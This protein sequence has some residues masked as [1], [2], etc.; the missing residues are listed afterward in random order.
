MIFLQPGQKSCV[1]CNEGW[2]MDTEHGCLDI[3]E[4]VEGQATC[5]KNTFCVNNGGSYSCLG[6]WPTFFFTFS[7]SLYF[8]NFPH[9]VHFSF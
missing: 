2:S 8:Q 6:K 4:C 7:L 5:A 3:D 9:F 1:A